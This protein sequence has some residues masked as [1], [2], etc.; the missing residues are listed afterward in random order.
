MKKHYLQELENLR[1]LGAEFAQK[2]PTIAPLLSSQTADPDVERILEGTAFLCGLIHQRLD[3]NFPEIT[4]GL[5]D[6]AAPDMMLPIPSQTLIRFVP[7]SQMKGIQ[8]ISVGDQIN[9]I[10][11]DDTVCPYSIT[12]SCRVL[13]IFKTETSLKKLDPHQA[14]L[15]VTLSSLTQISVWSHEEILFYLHAFAPHAAQWLMLLLRHLDHIAM[16]DGIKSEI[17]SKGSLRHVLPERAQYTEMNRGYA[18]PSASSIL[19]EYFVFPEKFHFLALNLPPAFSTSSSQELTLR[20]L[21]RGDLGDLPDPPADLFQINVAP[22]ANVF[23]Q[24]ATPFVI[25]HTRQEYRLLPQGDTAGQKAIYRVN[26]VVGIAR[27]NKTRE[28]YPYF[29]FQGNIGEKNTY[30]LRRSLSPVTQKTQWNISL[31]YADEA[32]LRDNE[33]LTADLLCYHHSLPGRLQVGDISMPSDT[34]PAMTSFANIT[35]PTL[36]IPAPSENKWLWK[37]FASVHSNLLPLASGDALRE[38]LMLHV[39]EMEDPTAKIINRRRCE[40]IISFQSTNTET[41]Y[42]GYLLR[43]QALDLKID[44]SS[45]TSKGEL[46]VFGSVLE[47]VLACYATV[48]SY[49]QLH[50][51]DTLSG[52]VMTWPIRLG[53]RQLL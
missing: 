25:P 10:P 43:G 24:S 42:R 44:G 17:G 3:E 23:P 7:G 48:N 14:E 16:T 12:R 34:S 6:I 5:M 9:S 15:T 38:F 26:R 19:Q 40:S 51:S 20:F 4:Q 46:F 50:L 13:P 29:S 35:K 36:P 1:T 21:L 18:L 41:L 49:I 22:A 33:T 52:D 30:S 45:F 27:G 11:I 31:L 32:D 37:F 39:P 28:F 47:R 8:E 53:N 2:Y